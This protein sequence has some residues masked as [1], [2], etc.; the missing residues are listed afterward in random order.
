MNWQ[1]GDIFVC[2]SMI[3]VSKLSRYEEY[4]S[5]PIGF[6]GHHK[7]LLRGLLHAAAGA[8]WV[9]AKSGAWCVCVVD[10]DVCF[11]RYNIH[12]YC[13]GGREKC[14]NN[15]FSLYSLANLFSF[16][17]SLTSNILK[18]TGPQKSPMLGLERCWREDLWSSTGTH[19]K[20]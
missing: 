17:V 3:L 16:P 13:S 2:C 11:H 20:H 15:L 5:P 19:M 1:P 7:W 6:H 9:P 10:M 12:I 4:D 14:L 8:S 18:T